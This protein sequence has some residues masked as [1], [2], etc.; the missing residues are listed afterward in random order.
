MTNYNPKPNHKHNHK[1]NYNPNSNH[2]LN[3]A[4]MTNMSKGK[5]LEIQWVKLCAKLPHLIWEPW[6]CSIF[7]KAQLIR[8]KFMNKLSRIYDLNSSKFSNYSTFIILMLKQFGC[9]CL[10][11]HLP[12]YALQTIF[13]GWNK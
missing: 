5:F 1:P 3:L 12:L 11:P 9:Y 8:S 4:I 7:L 10:V 6:F 2:S 13:P